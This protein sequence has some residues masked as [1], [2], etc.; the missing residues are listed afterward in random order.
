MCTNFIISQQL[1]TI[2][3]CVGGN[4]NSQIMPLVYALMS[5]KS[6]EFYRALFQEL[7]D[8]ADENG[9]LLQPQFILTDF[10]QAAINAARRE[11]Q[12]VQNKGCLFHLAQSIYQKIQASGLSVQYGTDENFSLKIRHIPALAFLPPDDM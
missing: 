8:F 7:I 10:E 2:H 9:I 3:G 1:Y 11:F 6:K 12:G 4:D 5:K